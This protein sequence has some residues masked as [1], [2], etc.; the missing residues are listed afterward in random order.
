M[1]NNNE[2]FLSNKYICDKEIN[3]DEVLEESAIPHKL[4]NPYMVKYL[5]KLLA[6]DTEI[7]NIDN[8]ITQKNNKI[9]TL[10]KELEELRIKAG[11][12][13]SMEENTK[14]TKKVSN[15]ITWKREIVLVKEEDKIDILKSLNQRN[16]LVGKIRFVE[17]EGIVTWLSVRIWDVDIWY[18][19][20]EDP[21][22]FILPEFILNAQ[23]NTELFQDDSSWDV[24][25]EDIKEIIVEDTKYTF[26]D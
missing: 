26:M 7:A 17:G 18:E 1:V 6:L 3:V 14:D 21:Y 4:P 9:I 19:G 15:N 8:Y 20:E 11:M 2:E 5:L 22:V 16:I 12:P 23:W 25:I 24:L 10:N 13:K